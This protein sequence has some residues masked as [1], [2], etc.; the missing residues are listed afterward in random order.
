MKKIVFNQPAEIWE[1]GLPLG[2]GKQG[3]MFF[4]PPDNMQF[5]CNEDSL[6]YGGPRERNNPDCKTFMPKIQKLIFE[7]NIIEAQKLMKSAMTGL[8][9]YQRHYEPAGTIFLSNQEQGDLVDYTRQ[10]NLDTGTV[11]EKYHIGETYY[12]MESFASYPDNLM[13]IRITANRSQNSKFQIHLNRLRGLNSHYVKENETIVG[14][15]G[16]TGDNGVKYAQLLKIN[17]DGEQYSIG[18]YNFIEKFSELVIYISLS[19]SY[20]EENPLDYCK[21]AIQKLK[22]SDYSDIRN[23]H[24]D[25]YQEI[26]SR[27]TLELPNSNEELTTDE[28]LFKAKQGKLHNSLVE[29]LFQYGRYLL[30]ASSRKGSL[31]ANLQGIW[32]KDLTP[33]WDSKFTIN[34]NTEMNYWIA[35]KGNLSE[36]H[37]PLFDLMKKMYPNGK[38]TA[39]I[40]YGVQGFVAHHNTDLW[41]DTAPQD[42]YLPA[43]YWPLGGVW[44]CLHIW[45]HYEYTEDREFLKEYFPIIEEALR[46]IINILVESPEKTLVLNPSVS[47]ENSFYSDK[48]EDVKMTYGSTMDTQLIWELMSN[49]LK[50]CAVV[51]HDEMLVSQTQEALT[52]LPKHKIGKYGQLME[53]HK[54]YEEVQQGHKHVSHLFGLFPGHKLRE[55]SSE[56]FQSAK[57]ALERRVE[58]GGGHTGWSAA[59]LINLWAHFYDENK[60]YE[61]LEKQISHSLLPNLLDDH[62]PFQIDGNFGMTSGIIEMLVQYNNGQI[63]LLPALP[64][65][66][67]T[68]SIKGV[69]LPY[70]TVISFSWKKGKLTTLS[71]KGNMSESTNIYLKNELLSELKDMSEIFNVEFNK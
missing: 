15:T 62:P 60:S 1:E 50:G 61:M 56:I 11:T 28:L 44:L 55:E 66:W 3:G 37:L 30:I 69:R 18:Q 23:R 26:F 57:V 20:R 10:L 35:E 9:E 25:D 51:A 6:W 24:L 33:A 67:K 34:I 53:W 52:K 45:E 40:M 5:Q 14:L 70:D 54:D 32:N 2:N 65:E 36:C 43:S 12:H 19:T 64:K 42:A 59:W 16:Q 68:G 29:L 38:K 63:Y 39:E 49:Y 31:P 48:G 7:E 22:I 8:P 46:F 4:G 58:N 13:V 27:V 41:G 21:N 71:I 47:P 17:S